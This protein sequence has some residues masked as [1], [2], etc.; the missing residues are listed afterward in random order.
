MSSPWDL[1]AMTAAC[2]LGVEMSSRLPHIRSPW[3][4]EHPVP[5]S[6][7][8]KRWL[9]GTQLCAPSEKPIPAKQLT[10]RIAFFFGQRFLDEAPGATRMPFGFHAGRQTTFWLT[11]G[12]E[13][14][15]A[16][17]ASV[18]SNGILKVPQGAERRRHPFL[19]WAHLGAQ[20]QT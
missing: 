3:Q 20:L 6:V 2:R 10:R 7:G 14:V 18:W 9:T 1:L 12:P 13:V 15:S 19:D 8:G 4:P 11:G 16:V 5:A 17:M